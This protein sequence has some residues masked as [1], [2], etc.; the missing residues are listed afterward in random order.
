MQTL[1][2]RMMRRS[3]LSELA[4]ALVVATAISL[5]AIYGAL[6]DSENR[7]AAARV[8]SPGRSGYFLAR[9]STPMQNFDLTTNPSQSRLFA[10]VGGW[11]ES[12][13]RSSLGDIIATHVDFT[14]T[15]SPTAPGTISVHAN[16]ASQH[17]LRLGDTITLYLAD[18]EVEL[19]LSDIY[20]ATAFGSGIDL[21]E[22]IAV[23]TGLAQ[24]NTHFLYRRQAAGSIS[25]LNIRKAIADHWHNRPGATVELSEAEQ[26]L[27]DTLLGSQKTTLAQGGIF[28]TLFLT[29]ALLTGKLLSFMDNRR[30]LAI[31]KTLGTKRSRM[32]GFVAS[33]SLPGPLAGIALAGIFSLAFSYTLGRGTYEITFSVF[34]RTVV[35]ALPAIV[36]AVAVPAR[37]AQMGT[38]NELMFERPIAMIRGTI[39]SLRR[40]LPQL[41]PLANRG[42]HFMQLDTTDGH[43]DGF[44]F[45]KL[46]DQ[47]RAGEVV[48][49][50]VWW[51]G[52]KTKEYVSPVNGAIVYFE[53]E[54]GIIGIEA[55]GIIRHPLA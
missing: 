32:A 9:E 35:T 40:R 45:R 26:S 2:R 13:T 1:L 49:L 28:L 48:A 15:V 39:S 18:G 30:T 27:G 25:D 41:D 51:W 7:S 44:I 3:W 50:T 5:L 31:L 37:M 4:L 54:V 38:V 12:K 8:V 46:G 21:G 47:V 53:R 42:V 52:I 36:I 14:N 19:L 55:G 17:G 34:M 24:M 16:I 29:L 33:G 43:F 6:L 10:F 23:H 22:G 20:T 11:Y